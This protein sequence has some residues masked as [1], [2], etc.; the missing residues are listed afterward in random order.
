M[1]DK[2]SHLSY[3]NKGPLRKSFPFIFF[4]I[5][6]L[7]IVSTPYHTLGLS[8]EMLYEENFDEINEGEG[9]AQ[10]HAHDLI[11]AVWDW[12]AGSIEQQDHKD[13]EKRRIQ[14]QAEADR[15]TYGPS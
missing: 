5:F 6:I 7:V 10:D 14:V 2:I 1:K 13:A 3:D 15:I 11:Q 4:A 8:E 12:W 9:H